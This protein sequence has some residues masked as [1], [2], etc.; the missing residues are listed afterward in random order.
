[1]TGTRERRSIP[2]GIGEAWALTT[3]LAYTATNVLLRAA[4]VD[5]DPWLGSMLRQVPVALLAWVVVVIGRQAEV[6]PASDRFLGWRFAAALVAGGTLAFVIGN[7]LNFNALSTGG[8]GVTASGTTAGMVLTGFLA[9]LLVLREGPTR[10]G[11]AGAAILIAGLVLVGIARGDI[12]E[13]WI[14]G[15]FLALGAGAGYASANV[16]TRLVQRTRPTTFV[17]LAGSSLGGLGP[18][19]VIQLVRGGGN[20]LAGADATQ[21]LLVLAAGCFNALA[22]VGIVQS[23][24]HVPV[25]VATSIQSATVVFSFIAAVVIFSEAAPP[26][27]VAG[28]AAVAVGIVVAQLRRA[29]A[30]SSPVGGSTHDSADS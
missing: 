13:G 26:L 4:A 6:W 10:Y 2:I 8:L 3:A 18:L 7:F 5:I 22:L 24:K 9:G 20:P 19:L 1:M 28:V 21:V 23:A 16:L 12:A 17:A 11:W 30:K 25:A 15:L 14:A 29:T 27:M